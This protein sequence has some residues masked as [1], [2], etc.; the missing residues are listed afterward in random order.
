MS[1]IDV[2]LV[3]PRVI[4][5]IGIGFKTSGWAAIRDVGVMFTAFSTPSYGSTRWRRFAVAGFILLWLGCV[6]CGQLGFAIFGLRSLSLPNVWVQ[7]AAVACIIISSPLPMPFP[8]SSSARVIPPLL[9]IIVSFPT[10]PPHHCVVPPLLLIV[11]FPPP[12]PHCRVI[13]P[14][15]DVGPV[16][17]LSILSPLSNAWPLSNPSRRGFRLGCPGNERGIGLGSQWGGGR[18]KDKNKP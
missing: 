12:S 16:S 5:H 17:P 14:R 15:A 2:G 13:L 8:T 6:H 18:R 3:M 11:S 4:Q 10:P 7:L 1:F 9:L